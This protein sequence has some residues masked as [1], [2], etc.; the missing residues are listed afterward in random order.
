MPVRVTE[1]Q[2]VDKEVAGVA[3]TA[4]KN[5]RG[6]ETNVVELL[7][8]DGTSIIYEAGAR[9]EDDP[10]DHIGRIVVTLAGELQP[11]LPEQASIQATK[12]RLVTKPKPP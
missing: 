4:D 2:A 3:V 11:S 8:L 6:G 1:G 5:T 12:V 7:F 9:F 10:I